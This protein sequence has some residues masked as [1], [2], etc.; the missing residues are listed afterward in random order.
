MSP[1]N[2]PPNQSSQYG[3][4]GRGKSPS[5]DPI[6][7]FFGALSRQQWD[8]ALS[9]LNK[10]EAS[11]AH[12]DSSFRALLEQNHQGPDGYTAI[13]RLI[14]ESQVTLLKKLHQLGIDIFAPT[15]PRRGYQMSALHLAVDLGVAP[16]AA[17]LVELGADLEQISPQ[18]R[19]PL[20]VALEHSMRGYSKDIVRY[21]KDSVIGVLLDAG[22]SL[23]NVPDSFLF[24]AYL[25]GQRI[26]ADLQNRDLRGANFVDADLSAALL[27]G[28][29]LQDAVYSSHTVFPKNFNPREHH[30]IPASLVHDGENEIEIGIDELMAYNQQPPP[31]RYY[32]DVQSTDY[33]AAVADQL[34]AEENRLRQ[35]GA[36]ER[37][38]FHYRAAFEAATFPRDEVRAGGQPFL[39]LFPGLTTNLPPG[40]VDQLLAVFEANLDS[41]DPPLGDHLNMAEFFALL[42]HPGLREITP[43]SVGALTS[44]IT[45]ADRW[46]IKDEKT[47]V[48]VDHV[49]AWRDLGYLSYAHLGLKY[50]AKRVNADA[51]RLPCLLEQFGYERILGRATDSEYQI[52]QQLFKGYGP[53]YR[54]TLNHMNQRYLEL[55]NFPVDREFY[56]EARRG[57]FMLSLEALGT[58]IVRNSSPHFGRDLLPVPALFSYKAINTSLTTKELESLDD[59]EIFGSFRSVLNLELNLIERGSTKKF[60]KRLLKLTTLMRAALSAYD[61]WKFDTEYPR[62][63][64][65]IDGDIAGGYNSIGFR[66]LIDDMETRFQA[67]QGNSNE[68]VPALA[69]AAHGQPA[70]NFCPWEDRS[71]REHRKFTITQPRLEVMRAMADRGRFAVSDSELAASEVRSFFEAGF[72]YQGRLVLV[73]TES[74]V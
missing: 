45:A 40:S 10:I 3:L 17:L 29:Q 61:V 41:F 27:D 35:R 60:E 68:V 16:S 6:V 51:L 55:F 66:A 74:E 65:N 13:H 72:H 56:F 14:L 22:A 19:T 57:Y 28:A 47:K 37:D 69:F 73:D 63:Y 50:D 67:A 49:L 4:F 15:Q 7:N 36:S 59:A 8:E 1:E 26:D 44:L 46:L 39:R 32:Y 9:F 21:S 48:T 38:I 20:M 11:A 33:N 42:N 23:E 31:W 70:W 58:L 24:G 71:G 34:S 52:E 43:E 64:A 30:M 18:G 53:G 12:H 2:H 25:Q 54:L 5:N 62:A